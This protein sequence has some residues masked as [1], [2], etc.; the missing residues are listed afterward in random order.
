MN[1]KE[2]ED[3]TKK[4]NIT[5]VDYAEHNKG[6]VCKCTYCNAVHEEAKRLADFADQLVK[7]KIMKENN[8][9]KEEF[10]ESIIRP[11]IDISE[12]IEYLH[13]WDSSLN[14]KEEQKVVTTYRNMEGKI[15]DHCYNNCIYFKVDGG[16]GPVMYCA[17]PKTK[18][19][20]PEPYGDYI[21][22][23]PDC[24]TGFPKDC[25]L[26]LVSENDKEIDRS[27]EADAKRF[28]WLL[29]GNGYFLEME[30]LP[31]GSDP[32]EQDEVRIAIDEEM[33]KK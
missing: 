26:P 20:F 5:A 19:K 17:H 13:K 11:A 10:G 21:I 22:H 28:R 31:G 1:Y 7:D 8:L 15:I 2:Y 16:P 6:K 25:P 29:D 30:D 33:R 24:D 18:E 4:N 32:K 23:H 27:I 3:F 12:A 14:F 9:I